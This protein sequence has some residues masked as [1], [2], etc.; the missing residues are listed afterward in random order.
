MINEIVLGDKKYDRSCKNVTV[1]EA[2][3]SHLKDIRFAV[4]MI[5][6]SDLYIRT[7]SPT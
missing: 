6:L 5:N 7:I 3:D 4:K 1:I 2:E